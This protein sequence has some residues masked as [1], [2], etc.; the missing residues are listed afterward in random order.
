[1]RHCKIWKSLKFAMFNFHALWS[2]GTDCFILLLSNEY[3]LNKDYNLIWVEW[4][5]YYGMSQC[6]NE[7]LT[8]SGRHRFDQEKIL[9]TSHN[10]LFLLEYFVQVVMWMVS[11]KTYPKC[12]IRMSSPQTVHMTTCTK[13]PIRNNALWEIHGIFPWFGPVVL[14]IIWGICISSLIKL[15]ASL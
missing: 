10:A 8:I 6:E 2:S 9:C 4:W 12:K 3:E 14:E 15:I 5:K 7:M 11:N 1:M 13:Y